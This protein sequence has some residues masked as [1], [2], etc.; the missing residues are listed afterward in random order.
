MAFSH[1]LEGRGMSRS[2]GEL[3]KR[4]FEVG[5]K[6][7][8]LFEADQFDGL[9]NACIAHHKEFCLG[10]VALCAVRSH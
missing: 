2:A 5:L 8:K 9:N 3:S 7:Q 1:A 6:V 10:V 4:R